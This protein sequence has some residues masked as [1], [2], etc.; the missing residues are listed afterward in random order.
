M[1]HL[2]MLSGTGG[3]SL[4]ARTDPE[5]IV[6]KIFVSIVDSSCENSKLGIELNGASDERHWINNEVNANKNKYIFGR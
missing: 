3:L 4:K 2:G 1:W 5:P 6:F